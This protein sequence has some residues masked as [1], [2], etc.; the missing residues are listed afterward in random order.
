MAPPSSRIEASATDRVTVG[1]ASSSTSSSGAP[2]TAAFTPWSLLALPV[3]LVVRSGASVG[4]STAVTVTVSAAFA[5]APAAMTMA[6]SSPTVYAPDTGATVTVVH[7]LD[8]WLKVAPTVVA[9]PS[10]RIEASATDRVAVGA[11]SSSVMVRVR[12]AGASTLPALDA[13]PDTGAALS[14]ASMGSS[15]AVSVTVSVLV[16]RPAAKVRVGFASSV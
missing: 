15:T 12:L 8:G 1:A 13:V 10:S 7:W 4:S 5:V 2:A 16:V 9:P 3:T 6:A 11:A 14:G